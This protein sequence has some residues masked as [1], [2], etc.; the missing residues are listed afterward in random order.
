MVTLCTLC[1]SQSIGWGGFFQEKSVGLHRKALRDRELERNLIGTVWRGFA[2]GFGKSFFDNGC[3]IR[4]CWTSQ[5][6]HSVFA[7]TSGT[8]S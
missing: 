4:R 7:P 3:P 2:G 1:K 6:W 8:E 5:Q